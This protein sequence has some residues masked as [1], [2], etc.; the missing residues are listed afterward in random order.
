GGRLAMDVAGLPAPP[1]RAD[2]GALQRGLSP[3]LV[4]PR[5]DTADDARRGAD[6]PRGVSPRG[7]DRLFLA[8]A[9]RALRMSLLT[10][11]GRAAQAASRSDN[12]RS[13]TR[14]WRTSSLSGGLW[15]R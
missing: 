5:G 3:G 14:L 10:A 15:W 6:L 2:L 7:P 11:A 9:V 13:S 12:S 4:E 1:A 8:R